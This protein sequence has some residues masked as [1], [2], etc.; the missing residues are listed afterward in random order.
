MA[1]KE[2]HE[3]TGEALE[4]YKRMKALSLVKLVGLFTLVPGVVLVFI[5]FR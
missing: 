5:A 2:A 3:L 4:E 1:V